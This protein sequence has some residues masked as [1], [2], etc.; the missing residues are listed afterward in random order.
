[1]RTWRTLSTGV[2]CALPLLFTGLAAQAFTVE[3]IDA[4]QWGQ[5]DADIGLGGGIVEDFED[6]QLA[7]GLLI[8]IADSQGQFTGT[9]WSVLPNIFDPVIGDPFGDSF[10]TG[11]WDG[12]H[13]LVNTVDNQSQTYG[14]QDW[15]PVAV[16]VPEG[17]DWIAVASQQ[18]TINHSLLVNGQNLGRLEALGFTLS[19]GP[20]GV[21]IVRSDDPEVPVYS[22]S[23]G[24]RGDAFTIDHVVYQPFG[25]GV[26]SE[27]QS[28]GSLKALF[29]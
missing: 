29:R 8:E 28:W 14:S 4:G 20:N 10:V 16:Q 23:F 15:R 11:V 27:D 12:S 2:L 7:P 3:T 17:A 18:V 5:P 19:T 25:G 6:L 1:M 22:V 26:S 21:L 13:V 9:G 24:G